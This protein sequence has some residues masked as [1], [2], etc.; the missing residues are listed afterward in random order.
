MA[1]VVDWQVVMLAPEKRHG[2]ETFA[3][4][5]HVACGRLTLALGHDPVFD[6]NALARVWVRPTRNITGRIDAWNTGL[7]MRIDNDAPVQLEAC[8]FSQ[9]QSGAHPRAH[10]HRVCVKHSTAFQGNAF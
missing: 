5:Q 2:V 4:P 1:D 9:T 10:Y 8:L 6:P 3:K 7:E